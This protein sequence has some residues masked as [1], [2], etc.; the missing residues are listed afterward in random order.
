LDII[1][2]NSLCE[3]MKY[4]IPKES[5]KLEDIQ[6][7]IMSQINALK[8]ATKENNVKLANDIIIDIKNLIK[9]LRKNNKDADFNI[10][11][12]LDNVN[13]NCNKL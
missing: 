5:S 2:D 8:L 7:E 6:Y 10:F 11:K 4:S 1:E 3:E 12:A 13:L 9:E